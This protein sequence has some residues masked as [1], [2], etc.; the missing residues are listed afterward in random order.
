[1][2]TGRSIL[3]L[4]AGNFR[5]TVRIMT[6]EEMLGRLKPILDRDGRV[7]R[8]FKPVFARAASDGERIETYLDGKLETH[9]VARVGD[10]I[11]KNTTLAGEEYVIDGAKFA[12]RYERTDA[13]VAAELLA[14]GYAAYRPTGKICGLFVTEE[15][16]AVLG[17]PSEFHFI[18]SWGEKMLCCLGDVLAYPIGSVPEIYRIARKEF[19]ETYE[20]E[21]L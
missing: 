14:R 15:L 20:L 18:A 17:L 4:R 16:L 6:Q 5:N 21:S 3:P 7:Y 10:I 1:M 19:F 2:V 9:R 8:K 13:E 11:I 12:Q